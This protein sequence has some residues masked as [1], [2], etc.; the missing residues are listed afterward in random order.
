MNTFPHP[1]QS[2]RFVSPLANQIEYQH[3]MQTPLGELLITASAEGI[4]Q[5]QFLAAAPTNLS[6]SMPYL[7]DIQ[8]PAR[9]IDL[10]Q[11]AAVGI[12]LNHAAALWPHPQAN[13][14]KLPPYSV[15]PDEQAS[16]AA[17]HLTAA[18]QQLTEYFAGQR[19]RFDLT[20][21]PIGTAF[22]RQVWQILAQLPYG[23]FCSYGFIARQLENPGAVRAVGAANGKNPIALVVPCHRVV[24][25]TGRLTGYAGGLARKIWLLQHE[26]QNN[27]EQLPI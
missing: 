22:Q 24:G 5:L 21:A 15:A 13:N 1:Q 9:Q 14:A 20:L 27:S 8:Q 4:R 6:Q 16:A 19:Q 17:R 3:L 11:Q 10:A 7:T 18:L 2:L 23:A 25:S 12:E 26:Q